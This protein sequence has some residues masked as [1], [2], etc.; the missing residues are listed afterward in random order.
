MG[1]LFF[2]NNTEEG[3]ETWVVSVTTEGDFNAGIP[4]LLFTSDDLTSIE[5]SYSVAADGQRFLMLKPVAD[6]DAEPV[7]VDTNLV[8]V[9]NFAAELR[10]LVPAITQ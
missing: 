7:A 5:G 1:D 6:E 9:E 8:L 2:R 4:E 3:I 10:R